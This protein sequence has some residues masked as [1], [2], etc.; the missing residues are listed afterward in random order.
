MNHNRELNVESLFAHLLETY[1][2]D[3]NVS[4]CTQP[5]EPIRDI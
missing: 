3:K 5:F 1:H 2:F 4:R